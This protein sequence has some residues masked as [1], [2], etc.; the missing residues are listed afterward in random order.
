MFL[1]TV[2]TNQHLQFRKQMCVNKGKNH[3]GENFRDM[4]ETT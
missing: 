4:N 1:K 2:N 3:K